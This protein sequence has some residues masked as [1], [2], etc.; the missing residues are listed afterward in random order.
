MALKTDNLLYVILV[1]LI[2]GF[3]LYYFFGYNFA[4]PNSGE[5]TTQPIRQGEQAE[6]P[7]P[8]GDD[9]TGMLHPPT[10]SSPFGATSNLPND[11]ALNAFP[12][13]QLTARDLLPK[14]QASSIWAQAYP[15]GQGTLQDKNFLQA[16][17]HVG[18]NT[19]G[20][21][22]RNA[23]LQLRSDPPNPQVKVSP[24]LQSTIEPDVNRRYFE[25]GSC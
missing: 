7:A 3:I 2:V 18:I 14:D 12:R 9:G 15:E 8:V 24:W 17:Y 16:G 10:P 1:I 11:P 19:V 13:D 21:N 6:T 25:I 20:Q 23:N 22:L 4:L 5:L